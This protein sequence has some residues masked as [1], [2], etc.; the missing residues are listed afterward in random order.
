MPGYLN[1][2]R[3]SALPLALIAMVVLLTLGTALATYS[4]SD[5]KQVAF[6]EK[7]MQAYYLARSGAD[8]VADWIIRNPGEVG[9]LQGKSSTAEVPFGSGRFSIE[10]VQVDESTGRVTIHSKGIVGD[11]SQEVKLL[12][13]KEDSIDFFADALRTAGTQPLNLN[14]VTIYGNVSSNSAQEIT[15][16]TVTGSRTHNAGIDHPLPDFDSLSLPS[17]NYTETGTGSNKTITISEDG[18]YGNLTMQNGELVFHTTSSE[19]KLKVLFDLFELKTKMRI[20]GDG[21]VYLYVRNRAIFQTP[22]VEMDKPDKFTVLLDSGSQ[23]D[24]WAN[25]TFYGVI[26]GPEAKLRMNGNSHIVGSVICELLVDHTS[27][28]I[29]ITHRELS[30]DY[31]GSFAT[32]YKRLQWR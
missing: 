7:S 13:S 24:I 18:Y 23:I 21:Q 17:R 14:N 9:Q 19:Q 26:Y 5:V 1:N 32:S 29:T 15:G 27:K 16:G 28:N 30:S 20:V 12:I 8:A 25:S 31:D 10:A 22:N 6:N 3:G 11:T 4:N 2:N